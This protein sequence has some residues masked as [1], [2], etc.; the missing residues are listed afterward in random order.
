MFGDD[1]N[2]LERIIKKQ[3]QK[4]QSVMRLYRYPYRTRGNQSVQMNK[5][6]RDAE[7]RAIE[8]KMNEEIKEQYEKI[9][10]KRIAAGKKPLNN[11]YQ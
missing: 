5:E 11:P 1:F 6:E 8:R 9:N 3:E 2:A 4:R 7:I 10:K